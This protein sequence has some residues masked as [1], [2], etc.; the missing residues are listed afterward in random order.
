VILRPSDLRGIH[1]CAINR[2]DE[3]VRR[4]IALDAGVAFFHA[5]DQPARQ[6]VLGVGGEHVADHRPAAGP[7]R[8][9]VD[10]SALAELPADQILGGARPRGGVANRHGADALRGGDIALEQQRRRPQ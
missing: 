8:Q 5:A 2:D 7:E 3:R 9:A 1:L 10:V 6:L 4:V